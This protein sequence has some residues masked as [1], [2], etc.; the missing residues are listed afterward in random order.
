MEQIA[1][2]ED[3]DLVRVRDRAVGWDARADH[4][5]AVLSVLVYARNVAIMNR[6]S[7]ECP[8]RRSSAQ[9]VRQRW[10]GDK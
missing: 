1:V 2:E 10:L 6:M 7:E 8:A 5:W 9:S 3:W 4:L